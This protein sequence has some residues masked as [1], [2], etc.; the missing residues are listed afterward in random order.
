MKYVL[1]IILLYS[2]IQKPYKYNSKNFILQQFLIN[3]DSF[4][5]YICLRHCKSFSDF[6]EL[7]LKEMNLNTLMLF[8]SNGT[9]KIDV[10]G[11]K[12]GDLFQLN[13]IKSV[14]TQEVFCLSDL[15]IN[16]FR[17]NFSFFQVFQ[18]PLWYNLLIFIIKLFIKLLIKT[19]NIVIV[20]LK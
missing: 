18:Q 2:L 3:F 6:G 19:L 16:F 5:F 4:T 14:R 8:Q 1:S 15:K 17:F 11:I 20:I 7:Y 13:K 9:C 12:F 10:S